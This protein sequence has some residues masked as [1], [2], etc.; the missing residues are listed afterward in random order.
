MKMKMVDDKQQIAFVPMI[1]ALSQHG[2]WP[3]KPANK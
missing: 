3:N 2:L 1:V